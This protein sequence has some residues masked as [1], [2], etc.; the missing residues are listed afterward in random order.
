MDNKISYSILNNARKISLNETQN[1]F[2]FSPITVDLNSCMA[3]CPW[4]SCSWLLIYS[5]TLFLKRS[6]S[7]LQTK[8]NINSDNLNNIGRW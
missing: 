2:T 7:V 1:H 3:F 4:T 8:E 5:A 6:Q